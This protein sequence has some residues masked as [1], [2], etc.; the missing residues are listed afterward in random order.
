L[1][2]EFLARVRDAFLIALVISS[3]AGAYV[4]LISHRA[5][6]VRGGVL[7]HILHYFGAIGVVGTLPGGIAAIARGAGFL[8][9]LM[10]AVSFVLISVVSLWLYAMVERPARAGLPTQEDRGWTEQDA[11]TSGL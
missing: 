7:A 6:K 10:V 5:E 11:R 3:F 1:D 9:I 4:A 2:A 8:G